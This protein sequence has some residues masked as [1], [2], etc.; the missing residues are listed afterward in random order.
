MEHTGLN[1]ELVLQILF[2][3][4]SLPVL[5]AGIDHTSY[6]LH[7]FRRHLLLKTLLIYFLFK[8]LLVV[9]G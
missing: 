9:S 2:R 6:A 8:K 3:M 7:S 4:E 1:D 5:L